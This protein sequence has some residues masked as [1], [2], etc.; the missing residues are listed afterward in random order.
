MELQIGDTFMKTTVNIA[1]G[2]MTR[3]RIIRPVSGNAMVR[4]DLDIN[5]FQQSVEIHNV[6]FYKRGDKH[7]EAKAMEGK[8]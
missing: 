2:G 1:E 7:A 4:F 3:T 5:V 6:F 8:D